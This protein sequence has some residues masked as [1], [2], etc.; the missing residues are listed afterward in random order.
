MTVDSISKLLA[1][2]EK[3]VPPVEGQS[4]G[5]RWEDGQ[6]RLHLACPRRFP[7]LLLSEDDLDCD[8]TEFVRRVK[9]MLG[10]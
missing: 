6:L 9:L 8:S 10:Y 1:A 5:I 3:A 4:H 2:L 7:S